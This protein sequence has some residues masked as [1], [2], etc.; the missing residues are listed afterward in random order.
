VT[1]PPSGTGFDW[2]LC[3]AH[4]AP[5]I[6]NI[7]P[8][9]TAS[10]PS[11][12]TGACSQPATGRPSKVTTRGRHPTASTS[13]R[14]AT[15][16]NIGI[17]L[18][19]F[20]QGGT[21]TDIQTVRRELHELAEW[22]PLLSDAAA[23]VLGVS[24]PR[25]TPGGGSSTDSLPFR[26]DSILDRTDEG[27]TGIRTPRGLDEVLMSWARQIATGRHDP[28]PRSALAYLQAAGVL[29]WA[30]AHDDW[31]ALCETIHEAHQVIGRITGH[32]D[33]VVGP[34]LVP[35]CPGTVRAD[36]HDEDGRSDYAWCDTCGA[37]Y[38]SDPDIY[39]AEAAHI[40][41]RDRDKLRSVAIDPTRTVTPRQALRVWP[42]L[43]RQDLQNWQRAG[44][45]ARRHIN[46]RGLNMLAN[47]LTEKREREGW[48]RAG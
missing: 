41:E 43:T 48:R 2:S 17:S 11:T 44:K 8:D 13:D 33:Q 45:L 5:T 10:Y 18:S 19:A 6:P 25:F 28:Q 46:L 15:T 29:E 32:T 27:A 12:V 9:C 34:C 23:T 7:N 4:S 20:N 37:M 14:D 16:A 22:R 21:L 47:A 36:M 38:Y 35:D 39:H 30:Q 24:S 26:L 40:V 1:I 31:D 3:A 42:E